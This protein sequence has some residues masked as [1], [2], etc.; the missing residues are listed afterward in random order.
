MTQLFIGALFLFIPSLTIKLAIK[1]PQSHTTQVTVSLKIFTCANGSMTLFAH[2]LTGADY[3]DHLQRERELTKYKI[4]K[5][6]REV[7]RLN[8]EIK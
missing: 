7:N 4:E 2:L 1:E 5:L 3:I 8:E 6:R